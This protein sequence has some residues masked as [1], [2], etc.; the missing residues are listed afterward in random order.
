[1]KHFFT[2][3]LSCLAVAAVAQPKATMK[4]VSGMPNQIKT[5]AQKVMR[6]DAKAPMTMIQ[7][8]GKMDKAYDLN[9]AK[10]SVQHKA[11]ASSADGV[12]YRP[13][14]HSLKSG[15]FYYE[16]DNTWGYSYNTP[17]L[18]SQAYK[19]TYDRVEGNSWTIGESDTAA[20]SS[21]IDSNKNF[22]MAAASMGVGGFYTPKIWN[23][24][25]AYYYYGSDDPDEG[26]NFTYSVNFKGDCSNIIE[27][28]APMAMGTYQVFADMTLY[29]GW[30]N[31]LE[32][33]AR[34]YYTQEGNRH[35][36]SDM[37]VVDYGDL[38]GGFVLNYLELPFIT[39]EQGQALFDGDEVL[40]VLLVDEN[41]ETGEIS[42]YTSTISADDVFEAKN[43]SV[44][45]VGFVTAD[46][47]GFETSIDPV[48]N[49]YV[50]LYIS[51]FMQEGVHAGLR[52]IWDNTTDDE[53]QLAGDLG[54]GHGY[55]DMWVDGVQRV[56]EDGNVLFYTTECLEPVMSLCGYF[57]ALCEYGTGET[58]MYGEIPV[59]G[60]YAVTLVDEE[61]G[62]MY[63][64]FDVETSFPAEY[65]EIL[66]CPEWVESIECD[67]SYYEQYGIL[68]IFIGADALPAGVEG[69]VGNVVLMSNG[70]VT[71]NLTVTQGDVSSISNIKNDA[72]NNV[73]YNLQGQKSEATS[74]LMIQNGKVVFVK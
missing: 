59:E 32:Y 56:D 45:H 1:M 13:S 28:V 62:D 24:R 23:K 15:I 30:A 5:D 18:F 4:S 60:G 51:G 69:R 74:G 9:K 11:P 40:E 67:D 49:G 2:I 72:K 52:M 36:Q 31:T 26:T 55:Y 57:N 21:W 73:S 6:F 63:N 47:D 34:D 54:A 20:E 16:D 8:N 35:V 25:K 29:S 58:T 37:L 53:T 68:A 44:A 41:L 66:E 17:Y 22:S 33:G 14:S 64:D 46:E 10:G 19:G 43:S 7:L 39:H 50:T 61:T 3:A 42:T 48:L 12:L 70:E 38:G 27:G 65:I 71:M